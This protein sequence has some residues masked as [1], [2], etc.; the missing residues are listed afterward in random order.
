MTKPWPLMIRPPVCFNEKGNWS[1]NIVIKLTYGQ[2]LDIFLK[3]RI[4]KKCFVLLMLLHR[5]I[6]VAGFIIL[7]AGLKK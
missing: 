4:V 5:F 3:I 6:L 2:I 1:I 7:T